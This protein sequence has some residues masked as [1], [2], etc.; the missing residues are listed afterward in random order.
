[1]LGAIQRGIVA[2]AIALWAQHA[3]TMS[4]IPECDRS[5][6]ICWTFIFD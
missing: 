6:N 3:S 4:K 5:H 1:M 2:M